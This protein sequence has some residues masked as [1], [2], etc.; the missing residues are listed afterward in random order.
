MAKKEVPLGVGG[1]RVPIGTHIAA[2]YR[3]DEERRSLV[4]PFIK[5]GLEQ[6]ARCI[7]MAYGETRD[8]LLGALQAVDVQAVMASG[9]L[10]IFTAA[11]TYLSEGYFSPQK[12]LSLLE[13]FMRE[14]VE[15]GIEQIRLTGDMTWALDG[16]PERNG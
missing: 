5:A 4:V 1:I 10:R 3:D 6:G 13:T 9:Q 16:R 14:A 7:S 8:A 12:M 11:E 15:E 2:F